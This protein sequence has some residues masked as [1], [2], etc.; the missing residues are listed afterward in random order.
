[1]LEANDFI[2]KMKISVDD[3]IVSLKNLNFS[4]Q[5]ADSSDSQLS[6]IVEPDC[7]SDAVLSKLV[8]DLPLKVI[9]PL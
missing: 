8:L 9:F 4:L 7:Y 1:M 3:L 5:D 2:G 6:L